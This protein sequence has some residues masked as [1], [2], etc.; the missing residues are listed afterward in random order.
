[1]RLAGR[2]PLLKTWPRRVALPVLFAVSFA[3]TLGVR[4]RGGS[5]PGTAPS[6]V[7]AVSPAPRA[8]VAP[9]VTPVA[10]PPALS[11]AADSGP[12]AEGNAEAVVA[13][14]PPSPPPSPS[15]HVLPPGASYWPPD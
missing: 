8:F 4:L 9:V 11:G 13:S 5:P 10:A 2:I 7:A 15:S 14:E 12:Q 6:P 1:M 3:A